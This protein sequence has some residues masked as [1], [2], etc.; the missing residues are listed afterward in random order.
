MS[1]PSSSA[2]QPPKAESHSGLGIKYE[3]KSHQGLP[4]VVKFSGGRSSGMMLMALLDHGVFDPIR[5]DVVIFN[6]TSAEHPATYDFVRKCA[7]YT[8]QAGIPFFWLEYASYED[9]THGGW[10]R[11]DSF[12]LVNKEPFSPENSDGYHYKGEVFEEMVSRAGFLPSRHTRICTTNLKLSTT[13]NFLCEWFAAKE[14][15]THKGHY[16]QESL[17][18]DEEVI[19]RHKKSR[20]MMADEELLRKKEYVRRCPPACLPQKFD[21]F[22]EIGARYIMKSAFSDRSLGDTAPMTGSGAIEYVSLIGLRADE[23]MRVSRVKQRN[24]KGINKQERGNANLPDGEIVY[25]PLADAEVDKD[26]VMDYWSARPWQLEL[27]DQSNLSNCVYC[28]MKGENAIPVIQREIKRLD[29]S[30]PVALRSVPNTPSDVEWWADLEER[31]QRRPVKRSTDQKQSSEETVTIGFW[32]VDAQRTYRILKDIE[33]DD[34]P[35]AEALLP[36]DCTD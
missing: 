6:N 11:H 3:T 5:G 19:A 4:H 25:T 20:G 32:G 23:P 10:S 30:L 8:E 34:I 12:R 27:P 15:T 2:S 22:S 7:D 28:F 24:R 36:C 26:A 21:D 9:A 31:Y 35:S 18:T 33:P 16:R 17:V 29:A 13:N 1:S 14:T